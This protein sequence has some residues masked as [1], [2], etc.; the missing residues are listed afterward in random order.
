MKPSVIAPIAS[1]SP[2]LST[3]V[4]SNVPTR[5]AELITEDAKADDRSDS[6]VICRI[7]KRHYAKRLKQAPA[8]QR[9]AA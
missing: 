9:K 3:V 5:L 2:K 8:E 6:Y 1:E 4:S 7:L